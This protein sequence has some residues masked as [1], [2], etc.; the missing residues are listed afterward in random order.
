VASPASH[1]RYVCDVSKEY[2]VG[3]SYIIFDNE[4]SVCD[5]D[6]AIAEV[7]AR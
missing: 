3:V 4:T 6:V 1:P 7:E 5:R 2:L